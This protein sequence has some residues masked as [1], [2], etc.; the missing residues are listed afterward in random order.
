MAKTVETNVNAREY[1]EALS[2]VQRRKDCLDLLAIMEKAS[3]Y[4]PK[5]WGPSIVGFGTYHYKYESGHEGDAP[6][7]AFASR[8]NAIV[9]YLDGSPEQKTA[10]LEKLG[11][12]KTGKG[13][14]YIK[15][16]EDIKISVLSDMIRDSVVSLLK[17]YPPK[18]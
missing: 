1:I 6:L 3:G 8:A 5:M 17:R 10:S 11:K 12:H 4:A 16:L 15:K 7:A 14:I 9:L 2:P 13:C 18:S